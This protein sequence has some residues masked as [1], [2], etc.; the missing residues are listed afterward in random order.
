MYVCVCVCV[1]IPTNCVY[2]SLCVQMQ[3]GVVGVN[4]FVSM[5]PLSILCYRNDTMP[6]TIFSTMLSLLIRLLHNQI[7]LIVLP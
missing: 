5:Q 4:H 1:H 3:R 2:M 7:P 6:V